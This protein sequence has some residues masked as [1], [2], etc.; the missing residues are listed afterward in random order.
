[1]C[2]KEIYNLKPHVFLFSF[3]HASGDLKDGSLPAVA[4]QVAE[5]RNL[6][7]RNSGIKVKNMDW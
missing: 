1:M 2:L 6:R 3:F 5:V 4:L 7:K